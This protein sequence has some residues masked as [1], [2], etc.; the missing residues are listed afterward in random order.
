MAQP[1][2]RKA[3]KPALV[4]TGISLTAAEVTVLR[5]MSQDAS[6]RV[7]RRIS[8]SSIVRALVQWMDAQPPDFVR[9]EI[10]PLVEKELALLRWGRKKL[11]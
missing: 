8:S 4:L 7:G 2:A 11:T 9:T 1:P 10:L 6:D 5:S 3:P